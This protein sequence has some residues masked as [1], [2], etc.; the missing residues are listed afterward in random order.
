MSRALPIAEALYLGYSFFFL[1]DNSTSHFV[2]AKDALQAKNMNKGI[3]G[4]QPILRD[5][6]FDN[7]KGVQVI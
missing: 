1:F 6:W 3:G 2:Y 4:S 7:Q 5:G